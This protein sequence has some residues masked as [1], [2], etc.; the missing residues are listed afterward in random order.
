MEEQ[1][2]LAIT[3]GKNIT[4][5]RKLSGM[6]QL[7]LAEKLNYSDKSVSKWEQGNGMPDVRILVQLADLFNVTVDDLVREHPKGKVLPKRARRIM[8]FI[9]TSCAVG[10][11]W[12]VAVV[13]FVFLGIFAPALK[14]EWL[15]FVYAIP[16]SAIVLVVFSSVW[17]WKWLRLI[18][19]SVLIWTTLACAYLT[20]FVCGYGG[21]NIWLI[22]LIGVP[23]QVL[24]LFYFI[25]RKK[26]PLKE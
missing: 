3:I 8:R 11:C 12:L 21:Y 14:N 5:L 16:V 19:L 23:L 25:W 13:C 1:D 10:L 17:H 18:S 15:A 26:R 22:F 20:A 2:S 7:A 6:T 24:A 9:V 4:R